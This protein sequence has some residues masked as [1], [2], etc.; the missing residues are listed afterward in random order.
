[1]KKQLGITKESGDMRLQLFEKIDK[2]ID[3][4]TTN[5]EI[6]EIIR[7]ELKYSIIDALSESDYVISIASRV[8]N[9]DS[10]REKIIRNNYYLRY[11]TP[12]EILNNLSD[13]IG[14]KIECRFIEEEGKVYAELNKKFNIDY[15]DGFC[16]NDRYPN[17]RINTKSTQPQ[18]QRNGFSIYRLD[19]YYMNGEEHINFE[20][21]IKSLVNSFWSDIEHKLVYKNT[22]YYVF[23]TFMKSLL[24]SIKASLTITDRQLHIV[25]DEMNKGSQPNSAFDDRVSLELL[26]SKSI[27]DLFTEKLRESIGFTINLKETSNILGHFLVRK[28]ITNLDEDTDAAINL[29]EMFTTLKEENID[30]TDNIEFETNIDEN[31]V[32]KKILGTHLIETMNLD[33]SWHVFFKIL[34]SIEPGNDAEDFNLFLD[35]YR[36]YLIDQKSLDAT[37]SKLKIE[38][39]K[40]IQE[41]LL[42]MLANSLINIGSIKIIENSHLEKIQLCFKNYIDKLEKRVIDYKDFSH[43]SGVYYENLDKEINDLFKF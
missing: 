15:P 34:F 26:I 22:N 9:A 39:R 23:D 37:F 1:M 43:F 41:E 40:K 32:F 42:M 6:Y 13:L 17:I 25:Y 16:G 7:K 31:D 18:T 27:N 3:I 35:V 8:K 19:G 36:S 14:L 30:F 4:L 21:Q 2:T 33:F 5:K 29:L 28:D 12:E 38:D 20:L 24:T 11:D 10:L